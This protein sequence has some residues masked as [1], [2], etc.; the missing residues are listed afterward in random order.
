MSEYG[1]KLLRLLV[2]EAHCIAFLLAVQRTAKPLADLTDDEVKQLEMELAGL[3]V[4]YTDQLTPE[5]V[6]RLLTRLSSG[7]TKIQ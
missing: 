5:G 6:D 7:P 2:A 3:R 1:E 4:G